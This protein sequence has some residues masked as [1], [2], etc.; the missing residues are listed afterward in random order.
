MARSQRRVAAILALLL[1]AGA[2]LA[3][4]LPQQAQAAAALP[5]I[6]NPALVPLT[7]LRRSEGYVILPGRAWPTGLQAAMQRMAPM[8]A[9]TAARTPAAAEAWQGPSGQGSGQE[10]TKASR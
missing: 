7:V 6:L 8:A 4:L 2:G 1:A 10:T 3:V 5:A 9:H